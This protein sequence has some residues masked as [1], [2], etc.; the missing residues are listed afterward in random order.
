MDD[1][2]EAYD[3]FAR[4]PDTGALKVVINPGNQP[5]A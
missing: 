1:M 3:T 5:A 4:A 2:I